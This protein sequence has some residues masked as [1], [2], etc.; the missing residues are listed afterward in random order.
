MSNLGAYQFV[1]ELIKR[2]GGPGKAAFKYLGGM[3]SA[4]VGV[5]V[6]FSTLAQAKRYGQEARERDKKIKNSRSYR[7]MKSGKIR[8]AELTEGNSFK[9]IDRDGD[10][11]II[12]VNDDSN[13]PYVVDYKHLC[14]ISD[15]K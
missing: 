14:R 2:A 8:N 12:A 5:G 11:V 6:V 9:V 15:Y 13:N 10:A 4:G 1:T 7:V 3:F